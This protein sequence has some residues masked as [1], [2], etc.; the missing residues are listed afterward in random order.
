MISY[1]SSDPPVL[2]L[3]VRSTVPGS[4]EI[5]DLF[6]DVVSAYGLDLAP[7]KYVDDPAGAYSDNGSFWRLGYPAILAIEDDVGDFK[8]LLANS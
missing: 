8:I 7:V 1:N 2:S 3:F 6:L 4:E 5:A